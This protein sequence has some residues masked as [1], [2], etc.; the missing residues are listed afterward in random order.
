MAAAVWAVTGMRRLFLAISFQGVRALAF[1]RE[2][3]AGKRDAPVLRL[4]DQD[5]RDVAALQ[6]LMGVAEQDGVEL[7]DWRRPAVDHVLVVVLADAGVR[8]DQDEV[9]VFGTREDARESSDGID[10]RKETVG[11]E[12]LRLLPSRDRG[13]GDPDHR[14]LDAGERFHDVRIEGAL[15]AGRYLPRATGK[16]PRNGPCRGS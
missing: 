4:H 16:R 9:G 15:A 10:R 13:G 2:I 3:Q 14:D 12:V 5:A 8:G 1:E 7:R 11:A 6:F